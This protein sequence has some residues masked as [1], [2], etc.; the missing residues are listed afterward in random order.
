MNDTIKHHM[1]IPWHEFTKN[2]KLAY[3]ASLQTKTSLIGRVGIMMLAC[4]TGAWRVRESMNAMARVLDVQCSADIGLVSIEFTCYQ[5]GQSCTQALSLPSTGINTIELHELESF[6]ASFKEE[7]RYLTDQQIN[8]MLD[9]IERA[10]NN[11]SSITVALAAGMACSA[12]VFLLGGGLVEMLCC[13]I[14]ASLGCFVRKKMN[15][16]HL[17]VLAGV[18]VS[19]TVACVSYSLILSALRLCFDIS[20][21]HEAGYIGAML[22]VIPGFPFITS[23][24]DISK[25]DM[26]SGLERLAYS[27]MIVMVATLIG[28]LVALIMH[29]KPEALLSQ[30]L[31]SI[32]LLLL[33]LPM[34]FIGV[35]GFSMMFNSTPKMATTAGIVGAIANTLRLE[36]ADLTTIPAGADALIGAF[37][38]GILASIVQSKSGYPRISITVPSMVVMVPGL[39][40]YRAVY[41]IGNLSLHNGMNWF[42]KAGLIMVFLQLGLITARLLTDKR[43]RYTN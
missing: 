39:Y 38:A 19:V 43:W 8:N 26:R 11:Y 12:F 9:R 3:Q 25:L 17:T 24:L 37:V 20:A 22:F 29:L 18:A 21:T 10:S 40:M 30:H 36:L 7:G 5:N 33:R 15:E 1:S 14:A 27:I 23:G 41:E 16:H 32:E 13:L 35:F 42:V 31:T 4:G 6:V 34:S 28:W 2:E